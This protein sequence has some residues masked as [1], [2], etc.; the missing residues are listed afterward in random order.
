LIPWG[1]PSAL[2]GFAALTSLLL[3]VDVLWV[4]IGVVVVCTAII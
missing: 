1:V 3:G 4:V 2:L